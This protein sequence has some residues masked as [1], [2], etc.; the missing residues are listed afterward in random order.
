MECSFLINIHAEVV[1]PSRLLGKCSFK[2]L[3][4]LRKYLLFSMFAQ[5][6]IITFL[7]NVGKSA[8]FFVGIFVT[9]SYTY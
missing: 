6:C 3:L 2:F 9:N 5:S 1:Y 8:G 4:Y 7:E